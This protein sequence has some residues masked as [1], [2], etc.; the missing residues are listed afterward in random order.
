[1]ICSSV[2]DK[3]TAYDRLPWWL[4]GKESSC[5]C[6]RHGF[7]PQVGKIPYRRKQQPTPLFLPG[8]SHGQRSL[9]GYSPRGHTRAGHNLVTK[10]QCIKL[11]CQLYTNNSGKNK[12]IVYF[13]WV[14]FIII[15]LLN[16]I[17]L[18]RKKKGNGMERSV[19]VPISKK[20]NAK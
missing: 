13:G 15:N 11:T 6:R 16:D 19:F 17:V 8:K 2:Y 20:G 10:Q 1:M 7:D 3:F 9:A 18:K 14:W 5:Q 4:S 12:S